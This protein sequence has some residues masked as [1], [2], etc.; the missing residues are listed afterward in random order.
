M[1][2]IQFAIGSVNDLA[3]EAA[4]RRT[5]PTKPLAKGWIDRRTA[6]SIA[7]GSAATGLAISMLHG[8]GTLVLG[9]ALLA[10]G[11]AYDLA[12][13]PTPYASLCFVVA[14]V[15]VPC[16]G[17]VGATG[18]LPPRSELLLPIAA[19]AGPT[20]QLANGLVDV[21]RDAAAGMRGP[22]VVLGRRRGIVLLAGLQA[23]IHGLA[24]LTLALGDVAPPIAL[25]A[26]AA[27]SALTVA[28]VALSA[29]ED[30]SWRERGWQAQAA[31]IVLLGAAWLAAAVA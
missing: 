1:L 27:A 9:L 6:G 23:A 7:A 30:P 22:A 20:L 8:P 11:L 17:W 28:G 16:Y 21:E 15:V 25:V 18:M 24:W 14:F 5:K 26:A 29:Q 31:A 4:D 2:A 3:D 13:K 10:A 19:L 12:L